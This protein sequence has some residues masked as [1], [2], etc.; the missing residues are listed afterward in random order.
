MYTNFIPENTTLSELKGLLHQAINRM[1]ETEKDLV[2]VKER[3]KRQGNIPP[4]IDKSS[5][6]AS[7]NVINIFS[8]Q[9]TDCS[10]LTL[11]LINSF[12]IIAKSFALIEKADYNN[13][14][15]IIANLTKTIQNFNTLMKSDL[16]Q[17]KSVIDNLDAKLSK[18]TA[19]IVISIFV[20]GV[21][22][23]LL[24]LFGDKVKELF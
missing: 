24:I 13:T 12:D 4:V 3:I 23:S 16:E 15:Y 1:Y 19:L 10:L 6:G 18:N 7:D 9:T 2:A 17:G 5:S 20:V 14:H 11:E 21:I 22:V 8:G